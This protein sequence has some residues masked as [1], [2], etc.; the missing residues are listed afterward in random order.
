MLP[1]HLAARTACA[2]GR[3]FFVRIVTGIEETRGEGEE[4]RNS[5]SPVWRGKKAQAGVAQ[6]ARLPVL[7]TD[8]IVILNG[9]VL[10]KPRGCRTR[11]AYAAQT[12]GADASG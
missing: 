2:A 12:I 8:T 1:V 10:E 9:E 4:A 11:G 6:T 7:G 5:M 3:L